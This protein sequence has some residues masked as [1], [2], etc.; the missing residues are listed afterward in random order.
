MSIPKADNLLK[1]IGTYLE[2]RTALFMKGVIIICIELRTINGF[3]KQAKSEDMNSA[4]NETFIRGLIKANKIPYIKQGNR[5]YL[6]YNTTMKSLEK[7]IT[8]LKADNN[9]INPDLND[10]S[11]KYSLDPICRAQAKFKAC[12]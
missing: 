1:S 6:D 7:M 11:G 5:T 8:D 3:V 10:N 2:N 9:S 12:V 4:I